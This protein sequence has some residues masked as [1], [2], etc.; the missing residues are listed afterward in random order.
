MNSAIER[1]AAELMN[2]SDDEWARVGECR[3][4]DQERDT[5]FGPAWEEISERLAHR[6]IGRGAVT[7]IGAGETL[8]DA[9]QQAAARSPNRV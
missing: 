2:L 7:T 4:A 3:I 9:P 1:L 5:A 6:E 8:A